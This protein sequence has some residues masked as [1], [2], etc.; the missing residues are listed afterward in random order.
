MDQQRSPAAEWIIEYGPFFKKE[1]FSA[2][3]K[4]L[5]KQAGRLE[6]EYTPRSICNAGSCT[7][8]ADIFNQTMEGE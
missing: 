7:A 4:L 6:K 2:F 3:F 5:T 8:E 1:I